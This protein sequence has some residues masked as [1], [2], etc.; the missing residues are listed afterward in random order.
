MAN[1]K[2]STMGAYTVSTMEETDVVPIIDGSESDANKN[3]KLSALGMRA[4]VSGFAGKKLVC[5]GDS[6]TQQAQWQPRLVELT[7]MIWSSAEN[8]PGTGGNKPM[9][10]GGSTIV[11]FVDSGSVGTSAGNSIYMRADDVN[12][13][14]PDVIILLGGQNDGLAAT[15]DDNYDISVAAYTGGELPVGDPGLPSFIAAYKGIL[16]KLTEQNPTAEIYCMA[17]FMVGSPSTS[18]KLEYRRRRNIIR[19]LADLY[20]VRFIDL[21]NVGFNEYSNPTYLSGAHP[22]ATGG[23]RMAEYIAKHL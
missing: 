2:I 7:G 22:T 1:T 11:P 10:V 5:L 20:S 4:V 8:S 3:K 17:Q 6:I 13:Y 14:S 18:Q 15:P 21:L 19:D 12:N 9:G 16:K 23:V